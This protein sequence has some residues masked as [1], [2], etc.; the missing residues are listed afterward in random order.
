MQDIVE[1]LQ[2][3]N[4]MIKHIPNFVTVLTEA[5][6]NCQSGPVELFATGTTKR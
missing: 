2:A 5:L 4:I 1:H 6:S 3:E